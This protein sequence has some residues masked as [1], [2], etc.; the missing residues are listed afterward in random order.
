MTKLKSKVSKKIKFI[1]DEYFPPIMRDQPWF[2]KPIIRIWNKKMDPEFKRKAFY[3]D[4]QQ[5]QEEYEKI[6]PMRSTD[7][8]A[9]TVKFVLNNLSGSSILEVGCGNGEMSI[10]C[11][12]KGYVVTATDISVGNLKLL[13]EKVSLEEIDLNV[14]FLNVENISY[15][16][17]SFDTTLCLHTIEHVRNLYKSIEELKRVTKD[18]IIVIVPKQRFFK[19]TCDYH[20]NFFGSSEQLI[21]AFGIINASCITIDNC[22]CYIGDL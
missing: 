5:F 13:K 19:Y 2:Y 11:A 10:L 22:L 18:R 7:M 3:F 17:K 16:D 20:L 21:Q 9:S 6:V 8:T 1:L 4:D 12:R 14:G 15:Q